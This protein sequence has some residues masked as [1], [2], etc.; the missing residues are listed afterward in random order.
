MPIGVATLENTKA[1]KRLIVHIGAP[2]CGSSAIQ[3]YLAYNH[4]ALAE[5]GVLVP[6]VDLDAHG[7]MEG[8]QI[9]FTEKLKEATA[10]I[11]MLSDR[12]GALSA[13]MDAH[14]MH[15]AIMSAENISGYLWLPSV[16][17]AAAAATGFEITAV[18][19]VRR[20]D[21]FIVSAWQQ[22]GLKE[23]SS[24][25]SYIHKDAEI[26]A[27]WGVILAPWELAIGAKRIV[28]RPFRRD[29]LLDGDVV[30]DFFDALGL[31]QDGLQP[32]PTQMNLSY[33]EHLGDLAHRIRDVFEGPHDGEFFLV[34]EKLLGSKGY[35]SRS[36]SHLMSLAQRLEFLSRYEEDNNALRDR[37]LPEFGDRPL[38]EPPGRNSVMAL[39]D[40]EKLRAENGLLIRAVYSLAKR[41]DAL[42]AKA[43]AKPA[44]DEG[45]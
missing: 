23:F 39:S 32:L 30:A 42:E 4:L 35:K 15:M 18:L 10:A 5:K 34:M 40:V 2:K 9:W 25:A 13:H 11:E 12:L 41:L 14:G 36:S 24:F 16:F 43:D 7:T 33:D 17:A 26:L 1:V 45:G 37:Y 3:I 27:T 19:Y 29:M 44:P 21:D 28:L 6:S 22:W 8:H 20:Q 38:F 31:S